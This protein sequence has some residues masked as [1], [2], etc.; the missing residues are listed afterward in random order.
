VSEE[1]EKDG[2]MCTVSSKEAATKELV[3]GHNFVKNISCPFLREEA[4]DSK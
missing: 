2:K 1:D 4:L 3:V